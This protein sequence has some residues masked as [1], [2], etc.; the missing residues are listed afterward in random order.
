MFTSDILNSDIFTSE[1]LRQK[2]LLLKCL[3]L[4]CF[5]LEIFTSDYLIL[6]FLPGTTNLVPFSPANLSLGSISSCAGQVTWNIPEGNYDF[7]EVTYSPDHGFTDSPAHI[8]RSDI[9][10]NRT[11]VE[12]SFIGILPDT[13]Y[14]VTVV[15]VF[16]RLDVRSEP[17]HISFKTG[18]Y[19]SS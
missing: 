17:S 3:P 4:K 10:K 13:D 5:D 14:N 1:V 2:C 6:I 7:F 11:R 16:G 15:T 9:N 18:W 8:Y 19:D 12:F